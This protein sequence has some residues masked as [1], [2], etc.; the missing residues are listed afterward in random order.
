MARVVGSSS[1]SQSSYEQLEYD[2]NN[3]T[4]IDY[5]SRKETGVWDT[6][7]APAT[8]AQ[9]LVDHQEI[10]K[11]DQTA[12]EIETIEI[13]AYE[14]IVEVD[15][16]ANCIIEIDTSEEVD[17]V[18][19]ESHETMEVVEKDTVNIV[20]DS[21]EIME[22]DTAVKNAVDSPAAVGSPAAD[23]SAAADNSPTADDSPAADDSAAADDS[24]TAVD[25]YSKARPKLKPKR[26]SFHDE[27][28]ISYRV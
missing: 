18:D 9:Y 12:N 16:T 14:E 3:Y 6:Q 10:V 26:I 27:P 8:F 22:S 5:D 20:S 21:E 4:D 19:K 7:S 25:S 2:A 13:D 23:D 15:Q 1:E 24:P 11:V 28:S 17:E